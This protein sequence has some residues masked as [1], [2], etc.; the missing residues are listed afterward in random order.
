MGEGGD[1]LGGEGTAEKEGG[2]IRRRGKG[3]DG[4]GVWGGGTG[5]EERGRGRELVVTPYRQQ[6]QMEALGYTRTTLLT[7]DLNNDYLAFRGNPCPPRVWEM[8][9]L[10]VFENVLLLIF[11]AVRVY[12]VSDDEWFC[13]GEGFWV[14]ID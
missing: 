8:V 9:W 6:K 1:Y 2:E 13:L 14:M 7:L 11:G 5:D 12:L 10:G 4:V 3:G